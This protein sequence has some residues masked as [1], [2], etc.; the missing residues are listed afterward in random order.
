MR[1]QE[2][3]NATAKLNKCHMKNILICTVEVLFD[4]NRPVHLESRGILEV[5]P[6]RFTNKHFPFF[7]SFFLG[8]GGGR[9]RVGSG[10]SSTELHLLQMLENIFQAN[11]RNER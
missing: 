5:H 1:L 10:I 11:T 9:Q 4:I 7:S 2:V 8:G 3:K 6:F